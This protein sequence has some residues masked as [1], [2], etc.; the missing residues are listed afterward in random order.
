[1]AEILELSRSNI[2]VK[3]AEM[4]DAYPGAVIER[5][6]GGAKQ[7]SF[8]FSKIEE[9]EALKELALPKWMHKQTYDAILRRLGEYMND[10]DVLSFKP[11]GWVEQFQRGG[12]IAECYEDGQKYPEWR[13]VLRID[14][15]VVLSATEREGF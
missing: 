11:M 10:D 3:I 13:A 15:C 1:M 8:D 7:F 2:S 5:S 12:V 14:N 6:V 9:G 4:A